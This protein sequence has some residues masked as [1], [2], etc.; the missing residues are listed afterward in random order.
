[1]KYIHNIIAYP[2]ILVVCWFPIELIRINQLIYEQDNQDNV[3]NL[4]FWDIIACPLISAQGFLNVIFH[5]L[6]NQHLPPESVYS[7]Q[8]DEDEFNPNFNNNSN[9]KNEKLINVE[10]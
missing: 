8:I 10:P 1:M 7:S 5:G 3:N 9:T 2:I 6:L 4:Q